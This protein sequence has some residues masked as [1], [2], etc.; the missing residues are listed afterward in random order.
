MYNH[1]FYRFIV[2]VIFCAFTPQFQAQSKA[3]NPSEDTLIISISGSDPFIV[4]N[5]DTDELNGI[6]IDIWE[7]MADEN[8]WQYRYEFYP[9]VSKALKAVENGKSDLAVG[10]I[11]ITSARV[12]RVKF[13][14]PYYQSSLAIGSRADGLGLWGRIKPLFSLKLLIAVGVFLFILAIVGTFLWLAERKASP[15]QFPADAKR[16]IGNGMWLAIVTMS[17][18]GYGDMAPVTLRGRII[19]GSWMVI[20]LIF[21][22]SMVAG[23]ASTL[24]L[25]GLGD[26][27]ITK[28]EEL[29]GKKSATV[30]GS[31]ATAFVKEHK[32]KSVSVNTFEE[33]LELL[34]NRKV[35][36]V[37]YDRPQLLFFQKNNKENNLYVAKAEYY[38][39]GYGFA[40]PLK[41]DFVYDVNLELLKLAE[42]H[43]IERIVAEYLGDE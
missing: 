35:E 39:Q 40:F 15:E 4:A 10:P 37:V 1:I 16:G 20:T 5:E 18:T 28:V 29:S 41:S 32:S 8:N 7:K 33:A 21:A 14:Q 43:E 2:C 27:T 26:S 38:K 31:P 12:K 9:T 6:S 22:T 13:S 24:T 19:A 23:I 34:E 42:D 30:A 3:F 11:S 17:T 25:T 36:A